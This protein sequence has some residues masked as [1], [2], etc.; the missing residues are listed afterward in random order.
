MVMSNQPPHRLDSPVQVYLAPAI[1]LTLSLP[2]LAG[3]LALSVVAGYLALTGRTLDLSAAE[4]IL[5]Q[6]FVPGLLVLYVVFGPVLAVVLCLLQ[7]VRV[8]DRL[9]ETRVQ[10]MRLPPV[11]GLALGIAAL[12]LGLLLLFIIVGMV[13]RGGT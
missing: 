8:L 10:R 13:M 2:I 4:P 5:R 1:S 6:P 11:N 9:S 7:R 12:T 3:L